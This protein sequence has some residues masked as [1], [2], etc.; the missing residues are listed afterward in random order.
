MKCGSC[1]APLPH[2]K[3]KCQ[4]CGASTDIDLGGKHYFTTHQPT[5]PRICCVCTSTMETLNV[6]SEDAPFYIE[7]CPKCLGLFFDPGELDALVDVNIRSVFSVDSLSLAG[8]Q[9]QNT[10]DE[11]CYRK[12]PV[13]KKIMNRENY[14]K[15][16]G[17]I[18]DQC[19]EHG[20]F[21]DAGELQRILQWTRVGGK[22]AA[23]TEQKAQAEAEARAEKWKKQDLAKAKQG[24]LFGSN[25]NTPTFGEPKTS[26]GKLGEFLIRLMD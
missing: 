9:A 19:R 15:S 16:S 21:L 26:L 11:V 8:L 10:G 3:V 13:C 24:S 12:C 20:V 4:Y 5:E 7:R 18:I 1:G 25:E 22:L 23:D 2:G 17:V 14:G 6:Q